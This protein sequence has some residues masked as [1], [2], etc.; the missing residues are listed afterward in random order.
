MLYSGCLSTQFYDATFLKDEGLEITKESPV[1]YIHEVFTNGTVDIKFN[2]PMKPVN[3]TREIE[4]G[5]IKINGTEFPVLEVQVVPTDT[6]NKAML[7]FNWTVDSYTEDRLRLTIDFEHK[8]HVSTY[9]SSEDQLAVTFFGF[10]MF[11]DILGRVVY[12]ETLIMGRMKPQ[13]RADTIK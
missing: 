7:A 6:S 9:Y 13:E 8:A 1:P 5:T 12:P 4:N 3:D 10:L 11:E 2:S